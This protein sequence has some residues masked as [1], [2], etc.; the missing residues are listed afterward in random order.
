[1]SSNKIE[2]QSNLGKPHKLEEE[3]IIQTWEPLSTSGKKVN[4][5]DWCF[6][7]RTTSWYYKK[8][9]GF[10]PK[11]PWLYYTAPLEKHSSTTTGTSP[12]MSLQTSRI[13]T[14]LRYES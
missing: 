7:V 4:V 6:G 8:T 13:F 9:D 11:S 2:I 14:K 3:Y 1:M 12:F 5:P 10:P